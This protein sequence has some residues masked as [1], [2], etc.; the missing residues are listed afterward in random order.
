MSYHLDQPMLRKDSLWGLFLGK[1]VPETLFDHNDTKIL[2]LYGTD[3][4]HDLSEGDI[5][6]ADLTQVAPQEDGFVLADQ[7]VTGDALTTLVASLNSGDGGASSNVTHSWMRSGPTRLPNERTFDLYSRTVHAQEIRRRLN[8]TTTG[9]ADA[10]FHLPNVTMSSVWK[11]FVE[12]NWSCSS[13]EGARLRMR[14]L[15]MV[16]FFVACS[17]AVVV[18]HDAISCFERRRAAASRVVDNDEAKVQLLQ[19]FPEGLEDIATT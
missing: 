8:A 7:Q 10:V 14:S 6:S 1:V 18:V 13:E 2:I 12:E 3:M 15:V 19:S 4:D 17:L 11:R 5:A 9:D 16:V